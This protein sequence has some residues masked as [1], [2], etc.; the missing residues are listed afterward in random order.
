M[1]C[2][3]GGIARVGPEVLGARCMQLF[4]PCGKRGIKSIVGIAR[5][6]WLV[7]HSPRGE[8]PTD[9]M[10]RDPLFIGNLVLWAAC[11]TLIIYKG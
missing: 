3:G 10:L 2:G 5:F 1:G 6:V 7:G 9:E 11:V 4:S 8:S